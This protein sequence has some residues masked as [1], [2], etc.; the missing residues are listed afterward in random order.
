[1]RVAVFAG[2]AALMSACAE[3]GEPAHMDLSGPRPLVEVTFPG[4][5]PVWMIFDTGASG[6]LVLPDIAAQ[7][8]LPQLGEAAVQSGAGGD[9]IP[10]QRTELNGRVGAYEFSATPAVV[11][12]IPLPESGRPVAGI[13]SP[14]ALAD[15]RLMSLNFATGALLLAEAGTPLP[16]SESSPFEGE[17]RPLPSIHARFEDQQRLCHL[18]TGAPGS[19]T[20]PWQDREHFTFAEAP[21]EAGTAT[22]ANG[23][24]PL[25][26]ARLDGTV[27]VGHIVLENPEVHLLEGIRGCNI[28]MGLLR[29]FV[30]T[31]DFESRQ[32]WLAPSGE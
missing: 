32:V 3:A 2:L 10:V 22:L 12:D 25:Y 13:L 21:V 15:G 28:G 7:L 8:D 5:E 18:D 6:S 17:Q 31:L 11:F 27:R 14:R 4:H 9:L 1:M 24:R 29:E 20:L 26:R 23:Q 16:E 19:L 30:V